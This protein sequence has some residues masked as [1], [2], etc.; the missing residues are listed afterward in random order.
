MRR[1]ICIIGPTASGKTALS[2]RL[3]QK[4]G[5]EIVSCDS[6]QLYKGFDIGSAK[7][8]VRE[9]AGIRH[10]MLDI[11][12]PQEIWS[13]GRY[14]GKALDAI[15][16]IFKRGKQP[17][18]CGGTG[19]YLSAV[20]NGLNNI[21]PAPRLDHGSGA[22]EELLQVDPDYA[23]TISCRDIRRICRALDVY[24]A[25]G[26]PFS[27]FHVQASPP[28]FTPVYIGTLSYDRSSDIEKRADEMLS[29]GL[30][31]ETQAL[32]GIGVPDNCPPMQAIGYKQA[33]AVLRGDMSQAECRGEIILRTRQYAKRQ[34][35][36]FKNRTDAIWLQR[37]CENRTRASQ[38]HFESAMKI[39]TDPPWGSDAH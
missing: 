38:E 36:W 39:L 25:T 21:P 31:E 15:E 35:T 34:M 27:S 11:A 1:L 29:A 33:R 20:T 30:I 9:R 16:Q 26:K 5:A 28:D 2:I 32:L 7:P 10:F 23:A 4:L 14:A 37:P 17:I 6:V 8:T 24:K 13:A 12:E 18:I 3:A 22:Y 19:L